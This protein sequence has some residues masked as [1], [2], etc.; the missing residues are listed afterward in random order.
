MMMN[1][2]GSRMQPN[3]TAFKYLD[4][5]TQ[6]VLVRRHPMRRSY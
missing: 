1:E 3:A 6:E 4:R 5:M 2:F